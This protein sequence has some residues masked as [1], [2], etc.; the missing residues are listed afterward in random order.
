MRIIAGEFRGRTVKAPKGEGTR[1]TT[2]RVRESLMSAV[3]SARGGFEGAVALDA[4]AG[5]G[6]LGLEALSRGAACAHFYERDGAA[7][8]VAD[9]NAKAL[10]L[11]A[12]RARV[13]RADVLKDPPARAR[14]PFDLV[15]LDPPYALEAADVLGMVARLA[16]AGALAPD[17]LVV[18]E[19]GAAACSQADD[20]AAACGF[21]LASRKKYGDTVV[22]IL[23]PKEL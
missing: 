5:S 7:A 2:D 4:F 13:H 9:G 10:G 20:A 16:D 18:Y 1:P 15:F 14:P 22:D 21:A 11:D 17:A 6:A 8:R 23:R 19:H 3:N 12:R